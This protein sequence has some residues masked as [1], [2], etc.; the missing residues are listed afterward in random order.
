MWHLRKHHKKM[1][2]LT[3]WLSPAAAAWCRKNDRFEQVYPTDRILLANI[4]EDAA[5]SS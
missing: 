1:V 4:P 5:A 3:R 2:E